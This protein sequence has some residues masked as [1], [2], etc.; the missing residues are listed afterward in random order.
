MT[1]GLIALVVALLAATGVGLVLRQRSG[2]VHTVSRTPRGTPFPALAP[3]PGA[4]PSAASSEAASSEA[5]SSEAASSEALTP[6]V[7]GTGLGERAT[8]VQFSTEFCAYCGPTREV[9]GEIASSADGVRV[10]EIDAAERMDLTKRL[11]VF[12]TPTVLVLGPDGEI[13][14][15][16]SGRPRKAELAQTVQAVLSGGAGA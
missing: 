5:A 11:R 6:A 2:K 8:L 15:R 7:L 12:T 1:S 14:A 4:D 9:L 10:V 13:A 3:A 16:S